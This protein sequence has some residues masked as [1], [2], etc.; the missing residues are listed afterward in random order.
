MLGTDTLLN[1]KGPSSHVLSIFSFLRKSDLGE[2]KT[3]LQPW[4]CA[5][6][7]F[8]TM[9]VTATTGRATSV[10]KPGTHSPGSVAFIGIRH[11]SLYLTATSAHPGGTEG[12]SGGVGGL[13]EWLVQW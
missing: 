4:K 3:A 11:K 9:H 10:V 1:K 6:S 5:A 8:T 13:I 7:T 12:I 2:H